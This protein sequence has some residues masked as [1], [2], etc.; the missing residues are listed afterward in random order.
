MSTKLAQCGHA[1]LFACA[2]DGRPGTVDPEPNHQ[3]S[4]SCRR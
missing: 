2:G 3:A 1:T 4:T